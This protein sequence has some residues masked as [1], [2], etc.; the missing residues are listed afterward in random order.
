MNHLIGD[1]RCARWWRGAAGGHGS[2]QKLYWN[3]LEPYR[4]KLLDPDRLK[5]GIAGG[6]TCKAGFACLRFSN[7]IF[8]LF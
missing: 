4:S 1:W 7:G 6:I 8:S 3:G 5:L 2:C